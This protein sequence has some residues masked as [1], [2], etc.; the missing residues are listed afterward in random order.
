LSLWSRFSN[1]FQTERVQ[2][3]IDEELRAHIEDAIEAGRDP[4]E[5]RKSFGSVLRHS[6]DSRDIKLLPWLDSVRADAIFGWRQ[7]RKRPITSLA[8]ILS[9]ALAIGS[10]TSVFRLADA[11]LLRPLPVR[12]ADEL[13]A[14][15]LRGVARTVRFE[16][17]NGESIRNS[18]SCGMP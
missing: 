14:M 12:H 7:L 9:L 2:R 15:V 4:K 13:Y 6:E 11:L 1:L 16:T 8:A 18:Y 10:C 3:E 5:I 17:A